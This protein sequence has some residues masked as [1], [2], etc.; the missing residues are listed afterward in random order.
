VVTPRPPLI[1]GLHAGAGTSTVAA[2]LHALDDGPCSGLRDRTADIVVCG[3]DAASLA[4]ANAL[5][6]APAGPRPLLA[7]TT[8]ATVPPRVRL[9]ALEERF[10]TV[11]LLPDVARWHGLVRPLDEVGT[12]LAQPV[13]HLPRSMRSYAAALRHLAAAVLRSGQLERAVPPF[14]GAAPTVERSPVAGSRSVGLPRADV[15]TGVRPVLI[16][17]PR[18]VHPIMLAGRP[19]VGRMSHPEPVPSVV[20]RPVCTGPDLGDLGPT[21]DLD[22]EALEAAGLVAAGLAG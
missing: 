14:V 18:P 6:L 22:D 21:P 8:G 19:Q 1:V 11:V 3:S 17:A 13:E 12:L 5:V 20:E 10:G 4:L 9:R 15:R 2:A 7:V 16:S